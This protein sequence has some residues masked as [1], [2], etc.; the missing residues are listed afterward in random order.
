MG[1]Y[2]MP[3]T[4]ALENGESAHILGYVHF[5]HK[6]VKNGDSVHILCY[7]CLTTIFKKEV[8]APCIVRMH[9]HF[10]KRTQVLCTC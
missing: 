6:M 2:L 1:R 7:V 4:C 3:L 9:F 5:N 10:D 8:R